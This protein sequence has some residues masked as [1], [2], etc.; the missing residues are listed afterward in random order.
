L[1]RYSGKFFL[2]KSAG[3]GKLCA[4]SISKKAWKKRST[5]LPTARETGSRLQDRFGDGDAEVASEL[6]F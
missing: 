5:F 1:G 2:T 3:C 6:R 4:Y